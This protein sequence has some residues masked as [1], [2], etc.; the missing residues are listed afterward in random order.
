MILYYLSYSTF[1][2]PCPPYRLVADSVSN[3][4][5]EIHRSL[6]L[7]VNLNCSFSVGF[8]TDVFNFLFRGRGS[9]P[10][11]GPGRFFE[12]TD[13]SNDYFPVDWY[14]VYD[15][16]GNGCK[17]AFPVRLESKIRLSSSVYCKNL[18]GSIVLKPK[19]FTEMIYV[20][21]VKNRC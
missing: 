16:L 6:K 14:I 11:T 12:L 13:F 7:G 10:P 4:V 9:V 3:F 19:T 2:D 15:K 1:E 8:R 18:D 21:L 17:V 20:S 5:A